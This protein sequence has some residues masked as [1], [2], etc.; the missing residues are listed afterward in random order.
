MLMKMYKIRPT[1]YVY[2]V[3]MKHTRSMFNLESEIIT[4]ILSQNYDINISRQLL[5]SF[6]TLIMLSLIWSSEPLRSEEA[7]KIIKRNPKHPQYNVG[8][9]L[10][11][12]ILSPVSPVWHHVHV[13]VQ[14]MEI[15]FQCV[16]NIY[17]FD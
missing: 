16:V 8:E 15:H 11:A 5:N 2:P 6:I 4:L 12:I 13:M 17:I 9:S 3:K 1:R 14:L 7:T 10:L